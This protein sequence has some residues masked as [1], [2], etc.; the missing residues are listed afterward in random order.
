M[1]SVICKHTHA[2]SADQQTPP[3]VKELEALARRVAAV[4]G[5]IQNKLGTAVCRHVHRHVM[6]HLLIRS[7][8]SVW[9]SDG[10]QAPSSF[11]LTPQ[12]RGAGRRKPKHPEFC[13]LIDRA[14]AAS[15]AVARLHA[16]AESWFACD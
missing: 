11:R 4:Q 12:V 6:N 3:A 2:C 8:C 10:A 1:T 13:L 15:V 16:A 7:E 5:L 14:V 9:Y